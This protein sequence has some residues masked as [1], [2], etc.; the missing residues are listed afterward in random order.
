[1]VTD[2]LAGSVSLQWGHVP[3]QLPAQK[4]SY[5]TEAIGSSEAEQELFRIRAKVYLKALIPLSEYVK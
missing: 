4:I 3:N 2:D 5:Q 1:M